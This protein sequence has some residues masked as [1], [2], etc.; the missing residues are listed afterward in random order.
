M[1]YNLIIPDSYRKR[2]KK[3]LKQHPDLLKQYQKTLKL[4]QDNPFHP[5]LKSHHLKGRHKGMS[6]VSINKSYRVTHISIK[7][8]DIILIDVGKHEAV[9]LKGMT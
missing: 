4:L 2:E 9:Y 6:S 5:S 1:K 3:F 7:N 8:E